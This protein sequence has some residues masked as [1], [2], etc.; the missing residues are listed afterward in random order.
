[1]DVRPDVGPTTSG[2]PRRPILSVPW[3][4]VH[5]GSSP[6]SHTTR[7]VLR[8]RPNASGRSISS[9]SPPILGASWEPFSVDP[10]GWLWKQVD[11]KA[12]DSR[13]R[14]RSWTSV[15]AAWTS[16]DQEVGCS[17]RPGRAGEVPCRASI[18]RDEAFLPGHHL[19]RG[20]DPREPFSIRV[21]ASR[22]RRSPCSRVLAWVSTGRPSDVLAA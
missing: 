22:A 9:P 10:V 19:C 6:K 12:H 3:P 4:G 8:P 20:S 7:D 18:G 13:L 14:G 11:S 5:D 1:V 2:P 17:S 16:T 15:D 21:S